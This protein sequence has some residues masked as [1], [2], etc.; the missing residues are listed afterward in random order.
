M[1]KKI[2]SAVL[3]CAATMALSV[4]AFAAENA[5][6]G[7][8]GTTTQPGDTETSSTPADPSDETSTTELV[9]KTVTVD[10]G[11]ITDAGKALVAEDLFT[12][13]AEGADWGNVEE[14]TF[15]SKDGT[16]ALIFSVDVGSVKGNESATTFTKGMDEYNK[17]LDEKAL[18]TT[19]TLTKED[20]GHVAKSD[21][22]KVTLQTKNGE[23]A[24]VTATVKV[25]V[26]AEE[27]APNTG[28]ALAIAP[29]A[30]AVS[31]VTVAA[32]MSKKKKG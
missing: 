28:I 5:T 14:I 20:A 16:F 1:K 6:P 9:E 18:S 31:F 29:A 12:G 11:E 22:K 17:D 3:A 30:L 19:Q 7:D 13:D 8:T 32:V 15:T 26:P 2:L 27:K 25:K 10:V 21:E 4:S 24:T 23:T